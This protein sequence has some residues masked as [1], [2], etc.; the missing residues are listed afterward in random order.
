MTGRSRKTNLYVVLYRVNKDTTFRA[1]LTL[2]HPRTTTT[3]DT[4]GTRTPAYSF[5]SGGGA[6]PPVVGRPMKILK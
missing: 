1:A 5:F 2:P 4:A 6:A 3:S